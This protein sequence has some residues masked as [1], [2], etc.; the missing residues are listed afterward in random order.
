M[1]P[2]VADHSERGEPYHELFSAEGLSVGVYMLEPATT[3][4]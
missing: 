2:F 3:D 4:S 1:C